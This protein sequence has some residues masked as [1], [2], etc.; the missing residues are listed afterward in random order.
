MRCL[1]G[2][3]GCMIS[4]NIIFHWSLE[5]LESHEWYADIIYYLKKFSCTNLLNDHQ[6]RT[7]RLS[8][9]K[10]YLIQGGLGWKNPVGKILR[11]VSKDEPNKLLEEFHV[12]YCVGYF[13]ARTFSHKVLSVGYYW[14]TLLID[15][16]LL[17]GLVAHANCLQGNNNCLFNP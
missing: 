3:I 10:F 17:L 6:R 13:A 14:P 15:F 12:G 11:C 16:Y 4:L 8:V 2:C 1:S 5:E 9:A 7:L